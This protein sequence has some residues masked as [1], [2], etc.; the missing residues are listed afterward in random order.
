MEDV[1]RLYANI[2]YTRDLSILRF[3]YPRGFWNESPADTEEWLYSC[4]NCESVIKSG[5]T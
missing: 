2:I 3:G 1:L 4:R 5:L